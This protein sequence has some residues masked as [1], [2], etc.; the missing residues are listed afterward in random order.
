MFVLA[1]GWTSSAFAAPGQFGALH[2]GSAPVERGWAGVGAGVGWSLGSRAGALLTVETGAPIGERGAMSV[3][4]GGT[5]HSRGGA[6]TAVSG[7]WLVVD[8][9]GIRF[10]PTLQLAGWLNE[11]NPGPARL[12]TRLAPGIALDAGGERWRFDLAVPFFGV[13]SVD[14]FVG[15][16]RAPFPLAATVGVSTTVGAKRRARIRFGLPE[17]LS[18]HFQSDRA[19]VEFGGLVYFSGTLWFKMGYRL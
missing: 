16:T 2:L 3:I 18:W 6:G 13:G 12:E 1:L 9:P 14:Q 17:G 8:R 15:V 11:F 4:V 7:R 19:Y 5:P 10:A